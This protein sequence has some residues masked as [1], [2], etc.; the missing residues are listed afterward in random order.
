MD[1]GCWNVDQQM[2]P[3]LTLTSPEYTA[4]DW[5]PPDVFHVGI[6]TVGFGSR[7]TEQQQAF[8]T[9]VTNKHYY[10]DAGR[11]RLRQATLNLIH[12]DGLHGRL[13]DITVPVLRMHGT[14]DAVYTVANAKEEMDLLVNSPNKN[15][16]V[17]EGGTH[18]LSA[19]DPE[20]VNTA[21]LE[22]IGKHGPR[23]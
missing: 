1:L 18:Y 11:R 20:E 23:I 4:P 12:R 14:K 21:V 16:I 9:K 5:T 3:L 7:L 10:G 13:E 2:G 19:S 15:F 6:N 8:W 17:I 22:L